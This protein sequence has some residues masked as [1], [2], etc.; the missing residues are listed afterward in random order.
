MFAAE[1]TARALPAAQPVLGVVSTARRR[2]EE[3]G[4]R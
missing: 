3:Q 4:T 1:S 2:E